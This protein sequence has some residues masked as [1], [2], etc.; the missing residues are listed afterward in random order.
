MSK[1]Q[2]IHD[3]DDV[4]MFLMRNVAARI[5]HETVSSVATPLSPV[6]LC[7][8]QLRAVLWPGCHAHPQEQG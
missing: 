2:L 1:Q 6:T 7:G 3:G 8:V 4:M 5:S